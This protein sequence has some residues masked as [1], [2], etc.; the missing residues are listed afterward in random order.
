MEFYYDYGYYNG[1][2]Y[3]FPG[4]EEVTEEVIE[5]HYFQITIPMDP[6]NGMTSIYLYRLSDAAE[7]EEGGL[8]ATIR[9]SV[10]SITPKQQELAISIFRSFT[11]VTPGFN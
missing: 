5:G 2:T 10:T 3:D 7:E 9:M 4:V 1:P 11:I 6:Q 8:L